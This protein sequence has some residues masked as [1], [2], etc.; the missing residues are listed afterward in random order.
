[1]A[2]LLASP[3][4][5]VRD[6]WQ[7]LSPLPGGR[8]LFM[9]LLGRAVPYSATIG[10]QVEELSPGFARLTL[11]DRRRVRNHLNSIHA[12]AL[13]NLGEFTSGLALLAGLPEGSRAILLRFSIEFVKKA[14]GTLTAT[15]RCEVPTPEFA[16]ELTLQPDIA[17]A[18]GDVV[19]RA[20]AVW[21]IRPPGA[22]RA[23]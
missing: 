8:R 12:I 14:R 18:A 17:D 15:C 19:A 9:W 16:G 2:P 20:T 4:T 21:S 10:A 7:R 23:T 11:R 13:A 6:S 1:M 5:F 22:A 3:G